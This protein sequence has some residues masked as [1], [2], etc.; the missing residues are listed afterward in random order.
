VV[1][2][3]KSGVN[4]NRRDSPMPNPIE[5][6]M[7]K[8]RFTPDF[9][10]VERDPNGSGWVVGC[11]RAQWRS[12][13]AWREEDHQRFEIGSHSDDEMYRWLSEIA[14]AEKRGFTDTRWDGQDTGRYTMG[15]GL[16]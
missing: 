2:C 3:H 15:P 10:T 16:S 6:A 1:F 13:D 8:A 7:R 12:G 5:E 9:V 11:H 4:G 14:Q